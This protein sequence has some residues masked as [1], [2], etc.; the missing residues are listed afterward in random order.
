MQ[1]FQAE[2]LRDVVRDCKENLVRQCTERK[3]TL[4]GVA[5]VVGSC[6]GLSVVYFWRLKRRTETKIEEERKHFH[7]VSQELTRELQH[8]SVSS[9]FV[10]DDS[11]FQP[12]PP[13][14]NARERLPFL[15]NC[16]ITS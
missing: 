7:K 9:T 10:R 12:V 11:F 14:Q 15:I 13:G 8:E 1:D 6:W 5:A 4:F 3:M 2:Q 16:E